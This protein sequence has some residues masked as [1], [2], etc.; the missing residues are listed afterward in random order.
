[1]TLC[2]VGSV[3]ARPETP[4]FTGTGWT[5]PAYF[6]EMHGLE[7][8]VITEQVEDDK[9]L[10]LSAKTLGKPADCECGGKWNSNGTVP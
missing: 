9:D 4:E 10:H 7:G 5:S 2:I 6:S 1:M 3:R 8:Y